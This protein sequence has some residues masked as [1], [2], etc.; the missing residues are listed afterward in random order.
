MK[1]CAIRIE[2][3]ESRTH[4]D[5]YLARK[6]TGRWVI[7]TKPTK[8]FL[9]VFP[10]SVIKIEGILFGNLIANSHGKDLPEIWFVLPE[11]VILLDL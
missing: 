10:L 8:E 5:I 7:N 2:D 3:I 1:E 6:Y 9:S 11:D 4:E